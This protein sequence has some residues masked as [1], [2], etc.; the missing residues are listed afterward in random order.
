MWLNRVSWLFVLYGVLI[1]LVDQLTVSDVRGDLINDTLY[2][3]LLITGSICL[4]LRLSIGW[5]WLLANA[6]VI[7]IFLFY[8][9]F[10][11][12]P[13]PDA[14]QGVIVSVFILLT[15]S[16]IVILAINHPWK[17]GED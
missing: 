3:I 13:L 6:V 4:M 8:A 14:R 9:C 12:A 1:I 5:W 7:S 17:W 2:G 15:I 11:C 10:L 16:S